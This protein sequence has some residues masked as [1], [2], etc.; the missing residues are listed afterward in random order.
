MLDVQSNQD[1]GKAFNNH[2]ILD[3]TRV[4]SFKTDIFRESND[5]FARGF[6]P[7]G[8]QNVAL[9]ILVV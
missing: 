7:A 9:N 3:D 4:P 6:I 1:G 8:D 5:K 2:C